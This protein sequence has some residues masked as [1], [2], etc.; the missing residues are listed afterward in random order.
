MAY[1]PTSWANGD[2][3]TADKLNGMDWVVT[4]T[5]TS[6]NG[7]LVVSC[8]KS[9]WETI[10]A[11]E[12]G[13]NVRMNFIDEGQNLLCEAVAPVYHSISHS[14][15]FIVGACPE[16]NYVS[17]N[18][19]CSSTGPD[20]GAWDIINGYIHFNATGWSVNR[21]NIPECNV[22]MFNYADGIPSWS[23]I[24]YQAP[25]A[26]TINALMMGACLQSAGGKVTLGADVSATGEL[27]YQLGHRINGVMSK[28][29]GAIIYTND[30]RSV[31][32]EA[33]RVIGAA[34]NL[35]DDSVMITAHNRIWHDYGNNKSYDVVLEF[36]AKRTDAGNDEYTYEAYAA[37]TAEEIT[38]TFAS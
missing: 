31:A 4:A 10:S 1:S 25:L 32:D 5:I 38:I 13:K 21:N 2:T 11:I 27:V 14:A 18:V 8:D 24:E 36:G 16:N 3:I 9:P 6:R 22:W 33:F 28:G 34:R 7:M 30:G 15:N 29:Q 26:D 17:Y 19:Y 37:V 35:G 12:G 20:T 23:T